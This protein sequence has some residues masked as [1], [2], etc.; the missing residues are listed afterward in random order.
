MKVCVSK[1]KP[2][3]VTTNLWIS[4][5]GEGKWSYSM[6]DRG[7]LEIYI[8]SISFTLN[9]TELWD[10]AREG[11]ILMRLGWRQRRVK[12]ASET[13]QSSLVSIL[14]FE[15][16]ML[17]DPHDCPCVC[18][19]SGA[20]QLSCLSSTE[21]ESN[22]GEL[23]IIGRKLKNEIQGDS[24]HI[25]E[26]TEFTGCCL[27]KCRLAGTWLQY[28][29]TNTSI[30]FKTVRSFW[31]FRLRH[32]KIHWLEDEV[33]QIQPWRNFLA[34]RVIKHCNTL[35]GEVADSSSF[36]FF[37]TRLAVSQKALIHLLGIAVLSV[38]WE[39]LMR[40][41]SGLRACASLNHFAD[42]ELRHRGWNSPCCRITAIFTS[43]LNPFLSS[44]WGQM[45]DSWN[46]GTLFC[47]YPRRC[48]SSPK[49]L[50]CPWRLPERQ[51]PKDSRLHLS[52]QNW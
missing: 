12:T 18:Q 36:S 44:N 32:N 23:Q 35:P 45:W 17:P 52:M 42:D 19:A 4:E 31:S 8:D 51:V 41:P 15:D 6:K 5:P 13:Q 26:V 37:K 7:K 22:G 33:K 14:H 1:F 11:Q 20:L 40:H 10:S 39:A 25:V 21:L 16:Q 30:I 48:C 50:S 3:N 46:A 49:C 38:C 43:C 2:H 24:L 47:S 28:A 9:Q 27:S 29:G 34:V